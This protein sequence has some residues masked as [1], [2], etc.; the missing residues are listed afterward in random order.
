MSPWPEEVGSRG[1][2]RPSCGRPRGV[3]TSPFGAASVLGRRPKQLLYGDL[4]GKHLG[5]PRKNLHQPWTTARHYLPKDAAPYRSRTPSGRAC[6][7]RGSATAGAAC[8]EGREMRAE[9]T[10]PHER[11]SIRARAKGIGSRIRTDGLVMGMAVPNWTFIHWWRSSRD[12]SARPLGLTV[13]EGGERLCTSTQSVI[14][15]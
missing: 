1:R 11:G 4:G 9:T 10:R 15:C 7:R 3:S 6:R 8:G 12:V 2:Q 13:R 14:T 5:S